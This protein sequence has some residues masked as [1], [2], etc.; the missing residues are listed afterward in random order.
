[1]RRIENGVDTNI[2]G[3]PWLADTGD[4]KLL[5]PCTP[6]LCNAKVCGLMAPNGTWDVDVL[7][8]LFVADDVSRILATP[9]SPA[10]RDS[11]R[12]KGDI[13]GMYSV[14]HGYRILMQPSNDAITAVEFTAW[15]KI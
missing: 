4:P 12:W 5:T 6:Q 13:K 1:M 2:W 10:L 11:W 8:D 15:D 7:N 14:K 3:W 9:V